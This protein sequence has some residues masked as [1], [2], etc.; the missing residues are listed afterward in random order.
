MARRYNL[1]VEVLGSGQPRP[2]AATVFECVLTDESDEPLGE[3]AV[4]AFC[5][6]VVSS[7]RRCGAGLD[8][9]ESLS[10]LGERRWRFYQEF[11]WTD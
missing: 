9:T 2:Y 6:G 11:P 8:S 7:P 5:E 10:K 1:L 4:R 3:R